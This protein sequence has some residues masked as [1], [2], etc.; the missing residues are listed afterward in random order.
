LAPA[1]ISLDLICIKQRVVEQLEIG[2]RICA[3]SFVL[4]FLASA[5]YAASSTPLDSWRAGDRAAAI[6]GWRARAADGDADANLYLA[7]LYRRGIEL[8]QDDRRA[9]E[10]FRAAANAGSPEAQYQLGLMYELG[11]GVSTDLGEASRWYG[12]S[13]GQVC[14]DELN[15]GAVLQRR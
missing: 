15:A 12:L 6:A 11:I 2:I 9:A 3:F 14:P 13:T 1:A 7:Y 5:T 8:A 10:H 4:A